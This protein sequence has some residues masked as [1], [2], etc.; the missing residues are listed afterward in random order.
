MNYRIFFGSSLSNIFTFR[1][2]LRTDITILRGW[3]KVKEWNPYISLKRSSWVIPKIDTWRKQQYNNSI[4]EYS[5]KVN[6]KTNI[7]KSWKQEAKE[8][9]YIFSYYRPFLTNWF[10]KNT[11][12]LYTNIIHTLPWS[13]L[14]LFSSQA[15][16]VISSLLR[17][18][19]PSRIIHCRPD[20]NVLTFFKNC[21]DNF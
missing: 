16:P 21:S 4:S 8:I 11:T 9:T 2:T 6:T 12:C 17:F 1:T 13:E 18:P 19:Y 7:W 14:I 10:F 20:W 3:G 5:T 15:Y